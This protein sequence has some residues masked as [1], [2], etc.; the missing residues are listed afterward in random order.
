MWKYL[1]LSILLLGRSAAADR[2]NL[3]G[4]WLLDVA[5]SQIRDS[6]LQ[7]ETLDVQQKDDAV[8]IAE[9]VSSGGKNR[10]SEYRC[11]VDGSMC[12]VKDL[13]VMLYYDGGTLIVV[14][15]SQNNK[16]VIKKRLTLSEDGQTL[17]IDLSH[18]EPA[19]LKGESL[20][21]VKQK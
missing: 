2:P 8:E 5:H 4:K 12:K 16:V 20:K 14:E 10:K 21:F 3:S 13:S 18:L 7:T 17:S 6:K 9:D 15:M 11:P 1:S 19:G